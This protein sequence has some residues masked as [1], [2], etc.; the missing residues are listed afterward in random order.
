MRKYQ[1]RLLAAIDAKPELI[2][3]ER[4]RNEVLAMLREPLEDLCISRPKSRLTW[5]ITM[6]FDDRFVTYVWFDALINMSPP[7]TSS[8]NRV[9]SSSGPPRTTS[10]P[11]TS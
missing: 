10:S 4:Y 7:S 5:G 3:P 8:V 6:P 2:R 11:R 9:L 1:D